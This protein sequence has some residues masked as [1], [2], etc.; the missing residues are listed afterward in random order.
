[1]QIVSNTILKS[2]LIIFL[3]ILIVDLSVA[4]RKGTSIDNC[5]LDE[6]KKW[7]E[8]GELERIEEIEDCA[9]DPKSMSSEKR[10]EALKLITE[11]YLYRNK[12]GKADKSF[13]KLLRV[14]PLYVVDSTQSENSWDLLYLSRT[15]SRRPIFSMYFSAGTNFSK[16]EMLENYGTDNTMTDIAAESYMDKLTVGANGGF[17]FEL[18]LMYGFDLAIEAN[19]AYRTYIFTDSLYISSNLLNPSSDQNSNLGTNRVGKPLLYSTLSFQENQLWIDIPLMLRYNVTFKNFLPYVYLGGGP[20]I[21]LYADI[22]KIERSTEGEVTGGGQ[23]VQPPNSPISLIEHTD[24]RN[25]SKTIP[26]MRSM[27]N[28]SLVAGAGLKFRLGRNFVFV[29]FRYTMMFKNNVEIQNRYA[30]PDLLYRYGHVDNDF[31]ND[32]FALTVGFIKS[33]YQP[34]KKREFNPIRLDNQFDKWLEKERKNLKRE[35]DEELK[36]E[37]NSTIKE[38]EREKPSLIEDV[39]RGRIGADIL[40]D[41]KAEFKKLKNK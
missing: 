19:F 25:P 5:Q 10:L 26:T 30:N 31:R 20:N 35:T 8:E 27:L 33:F 37:L 16:I 6:A 29:D 18:P 11:S 3:S 15:F 7:Y 2:F 39:E 41:K 36:N 1:M 32:N 17:G 13:R 9:S 28:W 14:N 40:K 22:T 23:I 21:L 4:Q 24:P 34:R 38:L 12:V